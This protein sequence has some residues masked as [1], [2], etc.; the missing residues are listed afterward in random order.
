MS[1][2]INTQVYVPHLDKWGAISA[3]YDGRCQVKFTEITDTSPYDRMYNEVST[4]ETIHNSRIVPYYP[5][6]S[7]IRYAGYSGRVLSSKYD[8][9]ER[10]FRY[11]IHVSADEFPCHPMDYLPTDKEY[12]VMGYDLD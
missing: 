7:W 5:P 11:K 4:Y 3:C 6:N 9:D 1:L 2:R 10:Q 12:T 8:A